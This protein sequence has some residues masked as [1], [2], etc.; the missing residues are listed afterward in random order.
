A[1]LKAYLEQAGE[2]WP[3]DARL[4][5]RVAEEPGSR[6]VLTIFRVLQAALDDVRRR[7]EATE[8][9][10]TVSRVDDGLLTEVRDNGPHRGG[11]QPTEADLSVLEMQERA[12]SGAGWWER[13]GQGEPGGTGNAVRFW[14]P[15]RLPGVVS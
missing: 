1:I 3:I 6:V 12:L 4:D 2:E 15:L 5:Y 13:D 14:L 9:L 8:V 7:A 10:V 11:G